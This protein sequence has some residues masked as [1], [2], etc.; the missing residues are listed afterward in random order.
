[1]NSLWNL[2]MK[3]IIDEYICYYYWHGN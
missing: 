2:F 3:E 1:M